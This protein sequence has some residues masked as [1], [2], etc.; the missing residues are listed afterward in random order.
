MND[1]AVTFSVIVPMYNGEK[2]VVRAVQSAI[3][4]KFPPIEIIVI[5]DQST[6]GGPELIEKLSRFSDVSIILI[7]ITKNSGPGNAR[8]VGLKAA[9]GSHIAFLDSDDHWSIWHLEVAKKIIAQRDELTILAHRPYL[10]GQS[11]P[12]AEHFEKEVSNPT[13]NVTSILKLALIQGYGSSSVIIPRT[14]AL[15]T[16]GF[17]IDRKYGED[18]EYYLK[19]AMS[20][21]HWINIQ[22]PRTAILGQHFYLSTSGL[23][24]QHWQMHK[25]MLVALNRALLGTPLRWTLP[26]LHIWHWLKFARRMILVSLA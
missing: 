2:T 6:D 19:I 17:P 23:S 4:Q 22:A 9:K 8:N 7:R 14:I 15:K 3:E 25:G 5:D 26:F 13:F 20:E 16:G 24:S 10:E 21:V 11:I 18:F 12:S 1:K